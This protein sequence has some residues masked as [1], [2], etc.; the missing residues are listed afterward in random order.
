MPSAV[1][2]T[3][4]TAT[5]PTT[6]SGPPGARTPPSRSV[7]RSGRRCHF[8]RTTARYPDFS[9]VEGQTG[10]DVQIQMGY[11]QP[12]GDD[13]PEEALHPG[14]MNSIRG[15]KYGEIGRG[16]PRAQRHRGTHVRLQH[17]AHL[18]YLGGAGLY[19]VLFFDQGNAYD[20]RIDL[21]NLKR[22]Y[23][24]GIRWV[25]PMGPLRLEYGKVIDPE[26]FESDSRWDFSIGTFF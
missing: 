13:L 26:E 4:S 11:H 1:S 6:T 22:S 19:G 5:P 15:F 3:R 8:T 21:S 24:G 20:Q 16:I 14:R 2:P 7:R 18:P 17:R 23:G 12:R 25:T 9:P 10:P